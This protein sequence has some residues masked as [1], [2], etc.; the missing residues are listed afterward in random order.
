VTKEA[1]VQQG[2]TATDTQT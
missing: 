1:L 2:E